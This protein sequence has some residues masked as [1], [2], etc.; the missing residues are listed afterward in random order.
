MAE[1]QNT[2]V[3]TFDPASPRITTYDIHEWI[4]DT[5]RVSE[6]TVNMIQMDGPKRQVYIKLA[7]KACAS[8]TSGSSRTGGIQTQHWG[9]FDHE[10][11]CGWYGHQKIRIA[12]VPPEAPD[13]SV[14][15]TLAPFGKVMALQEEM[16]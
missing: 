1:R 7:D 8:L 5:R 15:A 14:R 3:Y 13:V 2:I 9:N 12:N 16:W 11:C 10:Y 6:Q 4:H